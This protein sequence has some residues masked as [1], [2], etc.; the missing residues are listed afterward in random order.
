MEMM[1]KQDLLDRVVASLTQEEQQT[2][3]EK[4][5][6]ISNM[7]QLPISTGEIFLVNPESFDWMTAM[8]NIKT[9]EE[10]MNQFRIMWHTCVQN[11]NSSTNNNVADEII[12]N[13]RTHLS[14][15]GIEPDFTKINPTLTKMEEAILLVHDAELITNILL[16]HINTRYVMSLMASENNTNY[17]VAGF[18]D[19]DDTNN[20]GTFEYYRVDFNEV[21]E[22]HIEITSV[23]KT[24]EF[25][26][27][28]TGIILSSD[29][30]G[31]FFV[32]TLGTSED[33]AIAVATR[34]Y[35]EDD[36]DNV[37]VDDIRTKA[38]TVIEEETI[39]NAEESTVNEN[40]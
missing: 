14:G 26:P 24:D 4:E 22:N 20:T 25:K 29:E 12:S 40:D 28:E 34:I 1:E 13:I 5:P 39:I 38:A 7:I 17:P 31:G 18:E 8:A 37:Q 33:D 15:Y 10:N 21:D 35:G 36:A 27:D 6:D 30:A 11:L 9:I 16:M 32:Y 2:T 19:P 3:E 23:T